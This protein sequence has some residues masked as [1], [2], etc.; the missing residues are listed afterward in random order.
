MVPTQFPQS[1]AS[2][3][4]S[5]LTFPYCFVSRENPKLSTPKDFICKD[6]TVKSIQ[7]SFKKKKLFFKNYCTVVTNFT[8]SCFATFLFRDALTN[9]FSSPHGIRRLFFCAF[10]IL[11]FTVEGKK[12][13]LLDPKKVERV[14]GMYFQLAK[15][16]L[17]TEYQ[18]EAE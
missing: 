14:F 2:D 8:I 6:T 7:V 3:S 9:F 11:Q 1:N 10:H 13:L 18:E 17:G 12:R 15:L 4:F 5:I 16:T